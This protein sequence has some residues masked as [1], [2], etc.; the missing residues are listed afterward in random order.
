MF[1]LIKEI[2]TTNE[3][4]IFVGGVAEIIHGTKKTTNDID[5][6][7]LSLNGLEKFGK[8]NEFETKSILSKSGKRAFIKKEKCQIDI[9][10]ENETKKSLINHY[11]F[12]FNNTNDPE[13]KKIFETK[14]KR[15]KL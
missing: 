13:L 8:I 3:N 7:V 4:I 15:L 14:I 12:I 9:F 5:I 1:K 11:E 6:V 10:I 2:A